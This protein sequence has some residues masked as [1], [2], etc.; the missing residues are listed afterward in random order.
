VSVVISSAHIGEPHALPAQKSDQAEFRSGANEAR[1]RLLMTAHFD[2]VWRSL[3]RLGL[4]GPDADDGAQEV[5]LVASRKLYQIKLGRE[6]QF[7]FATA[8]RVAST[9]RRGTKRRRE[10]PLQ[11]ADEEERSEPGP[12]RL[13]EM[14]RARRELQDILDGMDLDQRAPFI[15]FEL[16]E[17]TVPEIASTLGI[18]IG[19]V[20]SR[21]RAA[22]EH[23][24]ASLRRLHARDA[25]PKTRP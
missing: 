10:E 23:F 18:P 22:R 15:L 21:L 25:F 8:V 5:F 4:P 11:S 1:L 16:E 7:L 14:S 19:T 20:S 12:E 24:Q 9:R 2:F 17:L 6:R 3:R 13:T